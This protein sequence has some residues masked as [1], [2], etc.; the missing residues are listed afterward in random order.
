MIY[1]FMD[2]TYSLLLYST[3]ENKGYQK[4]IVFS[5]Y[6]VYLFMKKISPSYPIVTIY[7]LRMMISLILYLWSFLELTFSK[8]WFTISNYPLFPPK[9]N[10]CVFEF[11][12]GTMLVSLDTGRGIF[13]SSVSI[14][15]FQ[16]CRKPLKQVEI[17]SCGE[18]GF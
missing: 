3:A 16:I 17:S 14:G 6:N 15:S 7:Q 11:R 12:K 4:V 2:A 9:R 8:F 18:Q 1:D 5:V 10:P 13:L